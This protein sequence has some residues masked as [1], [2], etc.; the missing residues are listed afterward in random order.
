MEDRLMAE[1]ISARDANHHLARLLRDVETGKEFVITR[2]GAPVAHGAQLDGVRIVAV[3]DK[4]GGIRA[5][6]LRVLAA[7]ERPQR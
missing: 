2:N 6:A 3:F 1:A 5:E 7:A 4:Q